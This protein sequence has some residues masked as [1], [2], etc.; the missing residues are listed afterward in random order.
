MLPVPAFGWH[1]LLNPAGA[2]ALHGVFSQIGT[3]TTGIKRCTQQTGQA[4]H[5][6]PVICSCC[7]NGT[8]RNSSTNGTRRIRFFS[9]NNG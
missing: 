8:L 7:L 2:V 5:Q 3:I 4:I 1:H 9:C 6:I